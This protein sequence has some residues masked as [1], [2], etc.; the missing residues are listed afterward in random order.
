M[1]VVLGLGN[2]GKQYVRTRHNVGFR[3]VDALAQRW[4]VGGEVR[5]RKFLA[6]VGEAVVAGRRVVLVKPGTYMNASGR[7]ARAVLDFYRLAPEALCVVSDDVNL[8]LGRLRVRRGGSA[9]G[10]RGLASVAESLGTDIFARLRVGVGAPRGERR[11][12][13]LSAF[14]VKESEAADAAIKRA[15]EAAACWVEEGIERCMNRYNV[16]PQETDG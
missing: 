12:Y 1:L 7:S 8:P 14:G 9:G 10:H 4:G 16:A 15:T 6:R 2:P 5:R 11:D 3:V 13:V